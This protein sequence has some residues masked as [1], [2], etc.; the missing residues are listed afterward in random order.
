MSLFRK[1]KKIEGEI[2]YYGLQEWW[3]SD[4]TKEEQNV[5]LSVYNPLGIGEDSLIKGKI[6]STSQTV[7]GLL[8]GLSGWFK[9]PEYR[10]IGYKIIKKAEELASDKIPFLD[11]HFLYQPKIQIYYRNRDNDEFALS[12]AIEACKQQIGIS[13]KAKEAFIKEMGLP[14]PG[15]VGYKQLCIIMEKQKNYEEVIRLSK[16]AKEQGW[17]GDWDRRIEKCK[18]K[19]ENIK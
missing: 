13:E 14:L 5:I 4:L 3:L 9:K 19:M 6:F 17:S 10:E 18:K 16:I 7:I 8:S 2:G 15:H 12:L 11:L 1:N